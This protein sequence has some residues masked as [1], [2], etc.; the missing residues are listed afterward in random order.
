MNEFYEYKGNYYIVLG[1]VSF[2]NP[3]DGK[4]IESYKYTDGSGREYVREIRD[5][6][7]KFKPVKAKSIVPV[8]KDTVSSDLKYFLVTLQTSRE[9][10]PYTSITH[11]VSISKAYIE[12]LE[13]YETYN[14]VPALLNYLEITKEDYEAFEKSTIS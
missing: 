8:D 11:G 2:K 7:E 13:Y 4:W 5:F 12:L 9:E 10:R 6:E 1:R 3:T 14:K